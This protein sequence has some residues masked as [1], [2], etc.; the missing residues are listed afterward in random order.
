[1]DA[2]TDERHADTCLPI[3]GRNPTR[4]EF[5]EYLPFEQYSPH[6]PTVADGQV[7]IATPSDEVANEVPGP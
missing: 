6:M 7:G 3:A 1:M 5:K 4:Q 2:S